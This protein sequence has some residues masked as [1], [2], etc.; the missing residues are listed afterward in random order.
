MQFTFEID[1]VAG[2]ADPGFID[3]LAEVVYADA[4]L[5]DA[6]IAANRDGSLTLSFEVEADDAA[7]ASASALESFSASIGTAAGRYDTERALAA[8]QAAIR[9]AAARP[10]GAVASMHLDRAGKVRT[11]AV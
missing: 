4:R 3:A 10:A 11:V 7:A 5:V 8:A 9:Q 6:T 2:L 1:T